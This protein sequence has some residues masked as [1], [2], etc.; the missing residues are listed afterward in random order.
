MAH[1]MCFT[2]ASAHIKVTIGLSNCGNK[3]AVLSVSLRLMKMFQSALYYMYN[4]DFLKNY[5]CC[6]LCVFMAL[7]VNHRARSFF[8]ELKII[9]TL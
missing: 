5:H 9:S 7:V 4:E 6:C 2:T 1:N 3:F 8:E